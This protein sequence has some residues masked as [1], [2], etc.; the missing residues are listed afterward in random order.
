MINI[1]EPIKK[2]E[3]GIITYSN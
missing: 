2:T 1:D 3:E